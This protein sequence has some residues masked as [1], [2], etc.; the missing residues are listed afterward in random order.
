VK[1]KKGGYKMIRKS[2]IIFLTWSL[3]IGWAACPPKNVSGEPDTVK[4]KAGWT[5]KT[6]IT[7]RGTRSEGR[8]SR[9][10]HNG[11]EVCP[12]KGR[13][14][15]STP[16]GTFIYKDPSYLWGWHGWQPVEKGRKTPQDTF[17]R[18]AP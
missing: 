2:I 10:Y 9:L 11:T 8:I 5:L 4:E 12:E 17:P 16:L 1:E 7:S 13:N 14:E 18:S 15:I 6:W 3:A